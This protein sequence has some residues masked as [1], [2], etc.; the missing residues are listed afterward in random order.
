LNQSVPGAAAKPLPLPDGRLASREA[1]SRAGGDGVQP[2]VSE[3]VLYPDAAASGHSV[4]KPRTPAT[5]RAT[6]SRCRPITLK[7]EIGG[8]AS[9]AERSYLRDGCQHG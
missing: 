8:Q 3:I 5:V 6:N 4:R 1:P 2:P 9:D 7:I